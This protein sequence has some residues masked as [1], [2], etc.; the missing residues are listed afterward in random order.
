MD[1]GTTVI[2]RHPLIAYYVLAVAI[3]V[4]LGVLLSISVL[5]GL[6]ALFGPA[7]AAYLVARSTEGRAGVAALRSATLRWRVHPGWYLAAVGLPL[8][9]HALGHVAYVLAGNQALSIPGSIQPIALVL[10]VLVIGE[11]IGW[12]GFLLSALLRDRS[13]VVATAIVA[14]AWALWHS[15]L[16]FI[17]GMPSY[18]QPFLAFAAWVL[19]ISFL[20]TWLWLGTKSVWLATIM[21]GSLNLGAAIVFP[22]AEPA[23]LFTF[24][25]IGMAAVAAAV[26]LASWRRFMASP[27]PAP[28]DSMAAPTPA[29]P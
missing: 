10:F 6:L 18:G 24:S 27:D 20:L 23:Q 16:Y 13:P 25:A 4:A 3:S 5:F 14:V 2:R 26:I 19:P 15:P 17:P 28:L 8:A 9:G 7:V 1:G 21:H 22:L 12:R 11:E 29:V